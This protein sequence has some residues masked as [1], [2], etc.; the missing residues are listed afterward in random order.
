MHDASNFDV[1]SVPQPH[2]KEESLRPPATTRQTNRI[3]E[4]Y[5]VKAT[6]LL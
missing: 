2:K 4:G 3:R 1:I 6:I 5:L